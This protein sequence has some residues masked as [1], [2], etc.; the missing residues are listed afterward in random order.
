MSTLNDNAKGNSDEVV[1]VDAKSDESKAH[2]RNST[3]LEDVDATVEAVTKKRKMPTFTDIISKA[4]EKVKRKLACLFSEKR[5]RD[6]N[7]VEKW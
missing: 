4:D 7:I 5:P 1:A 2:D 3:I 6:G